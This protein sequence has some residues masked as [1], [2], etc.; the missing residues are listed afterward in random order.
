MA[1]QKKTKHDVHSPERACFFRRTHDSVRRGA[2]RAVGKH[3]IITSPRVLVADNNVVGIAGSN[4]EPCIDPHGHCAVPNN[5]NVGY[6]PD[7]PAVVD[8]VHVGRRVYK[9]CVKLTGG[10]RVRRQQ[11]Q[12]QLRGAG[13]ECWVLTTCLLGREYRP[14]GWVAA[15]ECLPICELCDVADPPPK[16]AADGD[17]DQGILNR[18]S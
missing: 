10:R 11:L 12:L 9:S 4:L 18:T 1:S 17:R 7:V 15:A 14:R 8:V 3:Q 13:V 5:G 2:N 6:L 16:T